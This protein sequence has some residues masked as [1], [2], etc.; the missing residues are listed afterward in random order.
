MKHYIVGL[1]AAIL[2]LSPCKGFGETLSLEQISQLRKMAEQGDAKAQLGVGLMYYVGEGV[3][4]SYSDALKWYRLAA[5]QGNADAQYC[6][7][8]MYAN[9]L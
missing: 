6:L 7:G 2:L 4:K 1:L 8:E 3:T 9:G 5:Q